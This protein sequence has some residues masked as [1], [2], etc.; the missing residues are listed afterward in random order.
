[1]SERIFREISL[2]LRE[3]NLLEISNLIKLQNESG[4]SMK[5][6]IT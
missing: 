5:R 1:M 6:L 4:D 2:I 3:S